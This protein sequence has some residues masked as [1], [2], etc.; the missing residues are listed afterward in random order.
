MTA[1][2]LAQL[3]RSH[4]RHDDEMRR[5]LEAASAGDLDAVADSVAF[6]ERTS[7]RHFGDEEESLFPRLRARDAA[8]GPT[9]DRI[10]AE[11]RDHEARHARLRAAVEA[12]RT[13]A[14]IAEVEGLDEVYRRHVAEE[15][16]L[17]ARA[18]ALLDAADHEAIL[19][20][21][22]ARRGRSR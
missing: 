19:T 1:D 22:D 16:Q 7:P 15:D 21:M 6:L 11:H 4:R 14:V 13:S 10:A 18:A 8:L 17:F 3:D 20:E 9:L 2:A 5:L 12:G